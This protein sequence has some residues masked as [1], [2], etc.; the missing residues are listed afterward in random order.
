[1]TLRRAL[2]L[3]RNIIAIKLGME[4]G[5][6]A[7]VSEAAKFGIT[8]RV[9]AVPSIHI[10]SADVIPL[11]MIAAYT[12]FANLG[13]R[14]VPNSI[15]R[16]EDRSG[17][18]IWQPHGA[19]RRGPGQRPRLAHDRRAARRGPPRHRGRLGRAR[20]STSRPAARPAPPTTASTSGSSGSPPTS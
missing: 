11:E 13:V 9:P 2:Y 10:G 17:K 14:T 12:T 3:S 6:Q 19:H 18:I 4:L 16:V 1:M 5:E 8:T 15:L 7:V 20:G